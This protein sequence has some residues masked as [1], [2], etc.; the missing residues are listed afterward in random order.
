MMDRRRLT[1]YDIE[2][3][4]AVVD[5]DT[6]QAVGRLANLSIEGMMLITERPV[7]KHNVLKLTLE[8]P[9]P[10]LGHRKITFDAECRWCRKGRGVDWFESGYKLRDV[11]MEDQTTIMCLVLQLLSDKS[12]EPESA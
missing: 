3:Y 12:T 9:Q 4:Y 6:N 2:D 8:L 1:R 7:K 10:V 11:P 5:R